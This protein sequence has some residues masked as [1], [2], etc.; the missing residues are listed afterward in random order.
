V[1]HRRQSN[2]E[3]M[4]LIETRYGRFKLLSERF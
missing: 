1:I 4:Y 3:Q 2:W